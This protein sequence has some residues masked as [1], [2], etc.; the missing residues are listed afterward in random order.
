MENTPGNEVLSI[1]AAGNYAF[2][3]EAD[4]TLVGISYSKITP[5]NT[6]DVLECSGVSYDHGVKDEKQLNRII[7]NDKILSEYFSTTDP[8]HIMYLNFNEDYDD[9]EQFLKCNSIPETTK[10]TFND[11]ELLKVLA[12]RLIEA[13]FDTEYK[14]SDESGEGSIT[15]TVPDEKSYVIF[16]MIL[17]LFV[18]LTKIEVVH[19]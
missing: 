5:V 17:N 6:S 19:S 3:I 16:V 13:G 14:L 12:S 4:G 2:G 7:N 1:E 9:Y 18:F 10:I 15:V 11:D 8:S